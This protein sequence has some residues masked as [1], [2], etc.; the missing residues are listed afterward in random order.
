MTKGDVM[1]T[2]W[3][4]PDSKKL[5]LDWIVWKKRGAVLIS[6]QVVCIFTIAI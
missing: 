2:G 3:L 1:E 4:E 6:K 5:N